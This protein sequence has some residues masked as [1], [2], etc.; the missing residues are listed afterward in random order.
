ALARGALRRGEDAHAVIRV[1]RVQVADGPGENRLPAELVTSMYLG[2]RWEYLF[3][4]GAL[5]LRAFGTVPRAAGRHW[6][7]FPAN[8]CWAFAKAG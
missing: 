3:H 6:L 1:E 4:C 2:D 5:R 7:E 8:D